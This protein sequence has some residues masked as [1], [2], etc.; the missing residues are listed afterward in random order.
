MSLMNKLKGKLLSN[1]LGDDLVYY[2]DAE[3]VDD[4]DMIDAESPSSAF[5]IKKPTLKK[6]PKPQDDDFG[7]L[8]EELSPPK[9]PR[10]PKPKPK[11]NAFGDDDSDVFHT[12]DL[13]SL[14]NG[15]DTAPPKTVQDE[16][17]GTISSKASKVIDILDYLQIPTTFEIEK[18]I[19]MPLDISSAKEMFNHQTPYGYDIGE[20]NHYIERVRHSLEKYISLLQSRN[21]HVARLA[22]TI[23]Q[24]QVDAKNLQWQM[25]I[26]NGVNIMPT[27]D[28]KNLTVTVQKLQV[29][30]K[31]LK[32]Q[33]NSSGAAKNNPQSKKQ[34]EDLTNEVSILNRENVQLKATIEKLKNNGP[35]KK[36]KTFEAM[37]SLDDFSAVNDEIALP[38]FDDDGGM[39]SLEEVS[40]SSFD[41]DGGMPDLNEM[42]MPTAPEV[43]ALPDLDSFNNSLRSGFSDDIANALTM[44]DEDED[45]LDK[46]FDSWNS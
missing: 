35:A 4:S 1:D 40:T 31:K 25:E 27:E 46:I 37:P 19:L 21:E 26:A 2:D 3:N 18:D 39:P 5:N 23:D 41:D 11:E 30:N 7:M 22:S 14:L 12:E 36:T 15:I 8:D 24:L 20:I 28:V 9:K 38:S 45:E 6:K 33:V 43:E 13:G 44:A 34:I 42:M 16:K 10:K 17:R 29:E 32:Q